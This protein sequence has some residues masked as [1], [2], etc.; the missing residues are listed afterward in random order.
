MKRTV[1]VKV[2]HRISVAL[3]IALAILF[4]G[5]W[6]LADRSVEERN[7]K[8]SRAL[9]CIYGDLTAF[10]SEQEGVPID[11]AHPEAAIRYGNYLCQ[12]YDVSYVYMYVPDF[13]NEAVTFITILQNDS[14][15][16]K[17]LQSDYN[18]YRISRRFEP[19][20][21]AVWS[22]KELFAHIKRENEF[23][24]EASTLYC[25]NDSFG[26]RVFVGVD[27]DS[28]EAY[29]QIAS[30]FGL[31]ALLLLVVLLGIN[32][33]VYLILRSRV[34]RPAQT[35][36]G[37]MNR[38]IADGKRTPVKLEERGA[39]EFTEIAAAFN[40]M[41][42]R[43]DTYVEN[44][45][46]L[47]VQQAHQNAEL[48]IAS[49]IQQGILPQHHFDGEG[50]T[51]RA[52]MK[53]AKD[54]GGDLYDYLPLEDGRVLL[55]IADVS[56]KGI[57]ASMLML[58]TLVLIRQYAKMGLPPA[59]ILRQ[60]NNALAEENPAT[61]F[62][63]ALVG[64]YDAKTK[65]FTYSN[66]GHNLP[67]IIGSSLRTLDGAQGTLLGL[68]PDEEYA[69]ATVQLRTGDTLFLYTDGVNEAVDP[70]REFF[71]MKRL[72]A[73]LEEFRVTHRENAVS[74][75]GGAVRAFAGD[76]EQF[77]DITM[78]TLIATEGETLALDYDI[79]AFSALKERILRLPVPPP[80]QRAICLAA[81][82][83][84]VNICSYAFPE[85]VPEGEK[86]LVTI[87]RADR[88][89]LRF[90]D[91]GKPFDPLQNVGAPEDYDP[92]TQLGGL[93]RLIGFAGT[94]S[95][96]YEYQNGRNVLTVT[97]YFEEEPT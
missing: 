7:R 94:D 87:L 38:Y 21:M 80:Q 25:V 58:I 37:S 41:T 36:S 65:Q 92:D 40:S 10:A 67:Y 86:V 22:G 69:Q 59:E 44:L 34:S 9:A 17:P 78:L 81:E 71:G 50:Y 61:L 83:L 79:R 42:D 88:I 53:P 33:I 39:D 48:E 35:I 60:T 43:I 82:E 54:V 47:T 14:K 51:V 45:Q 90:S 6:F 15:A 73:A 55:V 5:A 57:P 56:G 24:D 20:E 68:F 18:G 89:S 93:G 12:W 63:T 3:L 91:G 97:F 23:G 26:N 19:E 96:T 74:F 1:A 31:I 84:F 64:I 70:N 75:V 62:A 28:K 85:G 29:R 30:V 66:A 76:A 49:H 46:A 16:D 72:E 52:A 4:V 2:T 95:R 27:M 77:D 8:Y 13:E 11:V 32:V